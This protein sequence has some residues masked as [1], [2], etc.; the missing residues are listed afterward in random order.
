MILFEDESGFSLHPKLGRMWIKKGIQPYVYTHSQ[1][2]K[3]LNVFGWVD[4]V[5]GL[6]GMMK[7][8]KGN[9]DDFLKLLSCYTNINY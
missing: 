4:P 1:H 8:V 3:R 9:T 7:W 2:H 5:N 6:H